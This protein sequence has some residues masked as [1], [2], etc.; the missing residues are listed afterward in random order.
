MS[1]STH[2]CLVRHVIRLRQIRFFLEVSADVCEGTSETRAGRRGARHL[3]LVLH[4]DLVVHDVVKDRIQILLRQIMTVVD[5]TVVRDKTWFGHPNLDL[6]VVRI[7]VQQD[8]RVS[9]NV[10]GVYNS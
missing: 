5:A 8:D 7:G 6:R 2:L 3:Y 1:A 10:C 9:K 4:P